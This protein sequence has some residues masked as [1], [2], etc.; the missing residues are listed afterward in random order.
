MQP[1]KNLN[2]HSGV[3]G[4]SV[5]ADWIRVR[6]LKATY[7]YTYASAGFRTVEHMK[8]LAAAGRGLSTYISRF[9]KNGYE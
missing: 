2:G 7:T 9:V 4:Y 8:E 6:F 3:L 5:G 1:Y